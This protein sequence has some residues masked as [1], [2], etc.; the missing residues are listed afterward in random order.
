MTMNI[1]N[2]ESSLGI[3]ISGSLSEG[4]RVRLTNPTTVELVKVGTFVSI[5]GENLKFFGVITDISLGASDHNIEYGSIE[6]SNTF[7]K[8]VMSGTT[9][10]GEII[11]HPML[12]LYNTEDID[13]AFENPL[14]AKTIPN[15]FA[16]VSS[17]TEQDIERVFGSESDNVFWVGHPLDMES[18]LCLNIKELVTRT[19]GVFGKSGTGKTFLT[20][21]LLIGILQSDSA[22]NLIFDMANEYGWRGFSEN[23][24]EVKGLKQLFPSKVAVFSLDETNSKKRGLTPDYV[25]KF[26]L[27]EIE[28]ADIAI[29]KDLLNLTD[30]ALDAVYVLEHHYGRKNWLKMFLSL[31]GRDSISNIAEKLNFHEGTLI[32]LHNRLSRIHRFNFID[33]TQSH[34]S[35]EKILEYLQRGIHVVLE[36]GRYEHNALAYILVTNLITRRIHQKYVELTE[37]SFTKN[38]KPKPIVITIEEAHRFL[39]PSIAPKTIFGTIAREMRKYNVTLLIVDQRPSS[40]DG[41]IMSQIGTKFACLLDNEKDVDAVLTGVH[42]SRKLRSVLASLESKQQALIFGHSLPM[43]VVIKTREYGTPESYRSFGI[44]NKQDQIDIDREELFGEN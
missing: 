21:L 8:E 13:T 5:N 6:N 1:D 42:G 27:E 35:V 44:S 14:P 41:E 9:T 17:A 22:S 29:L 25:V 4:I 11:V 19:N 30:L 18:K 2:N 23:I 3:V 37:T 24:N 28:Y 39:T 32:S 12:T 31:Q 26:G 33:K 40:I 38:K 16:K 7:V 20:R 34:Q 15:H 10:F 43:P 36:F